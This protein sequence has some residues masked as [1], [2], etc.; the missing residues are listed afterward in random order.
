MKMSEYV[1]QHPLLIVIDSLRGL[2][3]YLGV[4]IVASIG[5]SGQGI[6]QMGLVF[7]A[8]FG[9]LLL[10]NMLFSA[11]GW[12]YFYYRYDSGHI[13]IRKG[14]VFKSERS[15]K[16]ERVQSINVYTNILQRAVGL[17]TMQIKTAGTDETEVNLR[18]LNLAEVESI[19]IHLKG[20]IDRLESGEPE[21]NVIATEKLEGRNLWLAGATSGRFLVLFSVIAFLASQIFAYMP[22]TFLNII[23]AEL[24]EVPLEFLA[25]ALA[26]LLIL[27]YVLSIVVFVI[28]YARFR[29]DRYQ[30]RLEIRWGILKQNH[31]SIG[32]H[33]IQALTVQE[34]L[35]RQPLGLSS[36]FMEVAGGGSE[37]QEQISMLHPLLPFKD[38]NRFLENILPE[39]EIPDDMTF[40]PSRS[41]IRYII[42]TSIPTIIVAAAI[43]HT[44]NGV[45]IGFGWLSLLL[46]IPALVLALSRHSNGASSLDGRQLTLRF[47]D[48]NRYHVLIKRPH[49]QSFTLNADPIQRY[50]DLRTVNAPV[51]SSPSAKYFQLKDIDAAEALRI[52]RWYSK[53][54]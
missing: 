53:S 32:L 27:S 29:V 45:G 8:V 46:L 36:L 1:R 22:D 23:F 47:R 35:I 6:G 39:Y 21:E 12:F 30:D 16:R 34:G 25:I 26:V 52:W 41:R 51:L 38:V 15:I 3:S 37:D 2:P 13:H 9:G 10:L 19:R 14:I 49:L 20:G 33:R 24:V 42:R 31:V 7:L 18:A 50:K 54:S 5:R 11:L 40:L 4:A 17:A 43:W 44:V 48:I 28:Q